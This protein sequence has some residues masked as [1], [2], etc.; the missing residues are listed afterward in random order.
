MTGLVKKLIFIGITYRMLMV[1]PEVAGSKLSS[2]I[3]NGDQ[4]PPNFAPYHAAILTV[5]NS[6]YNY[7]C[8]GAIVHTKWILTS[9][10][11]CVVDE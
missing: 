7:K 2:R 9:A 6:V 8:G 4:A 10:A 1:W 3:Y 11:N 5:V